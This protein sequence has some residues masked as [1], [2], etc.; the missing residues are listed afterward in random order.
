M[1]EM[2]LDN[3]QR[4]VDEMIR[5]NSLNALEESSR[6]IEVITNVMRKIKDMKSST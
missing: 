6:G 2:Y 4:T 5:Y 1:Y 3:H